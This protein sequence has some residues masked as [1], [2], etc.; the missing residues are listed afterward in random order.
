M[1]AV[2]VGVEVEGELAAGAVHV[3]ML[4]EMFAAA[5]GAGATLDGRP[6]RVSAVDRL[7]RSDRATGIPYDIRSN[8]DNNLDHFARFSVR[9]LAIRRP[10]AA[11][12]DLAYLACGR[13]DGFWELRLKPWDLAAGALLIAEAGGR[14]SGLDGSPFRLES[15]GVCASN[16]RIHEEML[17]VLALGEHVKRDTAH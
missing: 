6:L 12:I 17:A 8:P 15:P 3:P 2:S 14:L 11:A 5:R 10:G 7:E 1:F 16:G 9:A 4:G 13:F